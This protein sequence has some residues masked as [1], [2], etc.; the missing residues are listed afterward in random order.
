MPQ[1]VLRQDQSSQV[2]AARPDASGDSRGTI[3]ETVPFV[4]GARPDVPNP[5][6]TTWREAFTGLN[7]V[8]FNNF[9]FWKSAGKA[10]KDVFTGAWQLPGIFFQ[11]V[12]DLGLE[13]EESKPIYEQ[14]K[15]LDAAGKRDSD[16]YRQLQAEYVNMNN[17]VITSLFED[18]AS[19]YETA[20]NVKK[21]LAEDPF[22]ILTDILPWA[23]KLKQV[24]RVGKAGDVARTTGAIA[25]YGD[26]TN[27][28]GTAI[29]GALGGV[30]RVAAPYASQY[31]PVVGNTGKTA[32][33]LANEYGA[34]VENTPG[35]VLSDARAVQIREGIQ[36]H[37][38]SDI[39][40][41]VER[42]FD[43][44]QAAIESRQQEMPQTYVSEVPTADPMNT[45][46][47][48]QRALA[49]YR[50]WLAGTR[51]NFRQ[52][53]ADVQANFNERVPI[54][55][56]DD[57]ADE[58]ID[59][60]EQKVDEARE[61]WET[62][63][64]NTGMSP[65]D[66]LEFDE[67]AARQNI[68]E[69]QGDEFYRMVDKQ[70]AM[71][72]TLT[73]TVDRLS[74]EDSNILADPNFSKAL[75]I[76][77]RILENT[78]YRKLVSGSDLRVTLNDIDSAR[79][80]FRRALDLAVRNGEI[81]PLGSGNK[82]KLLYDAMTDDLYDAIEKTVEA[83]NGRL[84]ESLADDAR[85]AKAEYAD[86]IA[87]DD[88]P[89]AKYLRSRENRPLAVVDGLISKALATEDMKELYKILGKEGATDL[90]G[91]TMARIFEKAQLN[92]EWAPTGLK[93]ELSRISS[94][95]PNRLAEMFGGG[96]TGR[97]IATKLR[98]LAAFS[99]RMGRKSRVTVNSPTGFINMMVGTGGAGSV[100]TRI[101]EIGAIMY[102]G[103]QYGFTGAALPFIASLA[104][105]WGG[106]K[107][108]ERRLNSPAG[109][110][111]MLE[112]NNVELATKIREKIAQHKLEVAQA[113]RLAE[114]TEDEREARTGDEE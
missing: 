51:E 107:W 19:K 16:E 101:T 98:E 41:T 102:G 65:D 77:N 93:R 90:Q 30:E 89:A 69:T 29:E 79:T 111:W 70:Y 44:T 53:F 72:P 58:Y 39:A 50:D 75:L 105:N 4:P 22:A 47:S 66:F 52:K 37:S 3:P 20:E 62:P 9:T 17:V 74:K 49:A 1:R 91:A 59:F 8:D 11:L 103:F 86:A 82:A 57:V 26:P 21:T 81:Q 99:E 88:S 6:E 12:R 2:P 106:A 114:R 92:G 15:A 45:E 104:L 56:A 112:G 100:L 25:E 27:L 83:S 36:M 95:S 42:R 109:R 96:D 14:L 84:P 67:T 78:S 64:D 85:K 94:G 48:G 10:V 113:A 35:M 71:L 23:A 32:E 13:T 28:P 61:Q 46:L 76:A 38:P 24:S 60:V 80:N 87:M 40:E 7:P 110:R 68:I 55:A 54:R 31:N 108:W 63:D 97:E 33:E 43:D 18:Y 34:G 73:E 5:D